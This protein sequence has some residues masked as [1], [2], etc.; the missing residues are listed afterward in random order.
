M[1]VIK[2]GN[3]PNYYT[4]L[5]KYKNK[6]FIIINKTKFYNINLNK[7]KKIGGTFFKFDLFTIGKLSFEREY[8]K[9]FTIKREYVQKLNDL[10]A[11]IH[12]FDFTS[13]TCNIFNRPN[14]FR[15]IKNNI[16]DT[17]SNKFN[18]FFINIK[19]NICKY[20]EFIKLLSDITI[21]NGIYK[22]SKNNFSKLTDDIIENMF[23]DLIQN[24]I[25]LCNFIKFDN[26]IKKDGLLI[27]YLNNKENINNE[28]TITINIDDKTTEDFLVYLKKLYSNY[29]DKKGGGKSDDEQ[30][31]LYDDFELQHEYDYIPYNDIIQ[32]F[33]EKNKIYKNFLITENYVK[34]FTY[35]IGFTNIFRYSGLFNNTKSIN[36]I[37]KLYH[38]LKYYPYND[39]IEN[40][41]KYINKV[42]SDTA[43]ILLEIVEILLEEC[44]DYRDI[45]KTP[46]ENKAVRKKSPK[47]KAVIKKSPIIPRENKEVR[48]T[49]QDRR[50]A[51]RASTRE[52][53][54]SSTREPTRASQNRIAPR[55]TSLNIIAPRKTSQYRVTRKTSQHKI[56]PTMKAYKNIFLPVAQDIKQNTRRGKGYGRLYLPDTMKGHNSFLTDR[57]EGLI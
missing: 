17:D 38:L 54:R 41:K 42:F 55:K 24:I 20:N 19:K 12:S 27:D 25:N 28:D 40:Q 26:L 37:N 47:N 21:N 9:L 57:V 8:N 22:L 7:K 10:D 46:P 43:K 33:K 45:K 52:P 49:S 16:E 56:A 15:F 3:Y 4:D 44:D 6:K 2:T 29:N 11:L 30:E 50:V 13:N 1:L 32:I 34:F 31:E 51:T 23:N 39:I 36:R 35:I 53:T 14:I 18:Y 48:K 5:S